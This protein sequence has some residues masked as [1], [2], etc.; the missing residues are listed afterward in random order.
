MPDDIMI[1]GAGAVGSWLGGRLVAAG[2]RV[3]FLARGRTLA[4]LRSE[5]LVLREADRETRLA[6]QAS[7]RSDDLPRPDWIVVSLKAQ[8][9]ASAAPALA[10]LIANGATLLT[11][12]NGLPWWFLDGTAFA[13]G[14][15]RAVDPDGA[16]SGLVPLARVVG[17]VLHGSAHAEGPG[18]VRV[19][20][21]D[22]LLLGAPRRESAGDARRIADVLRASGVPA[23]VVPDIRSAIWVKLWGNMT[24]N[25]ISALTRAGLTD[26]LADPLLRDL[27]AGMMREMEA[28]GRPL[29]LPLP[30]SVEDRMAV[31]ARLG[32]V[33][34]SMLQDLEA[35]RPLEIEP[36][37]GAVVELAGRVG[38]A[39]PLSRSVVGLARQLARSSA[40]ERQG[41][42][43]ASRKP[44]ASTE[45]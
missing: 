45:S 35:R 25:P 8:D 24:M 30:M 39:A 5:G 16:T 23:E 9:V 7:D 32:N 21:I 4:A 11:V 31:T 22:R 15:L 1:Y 29:G 26:I 10:S 38:V 37:L 44:P 3:G 6:V 28:V 34:T 43:A 14:P 20:R 18:I 42:G 17:G 13:D 27:V 12:Q 40:A 41:P 36:I 2:H 33:R 19:N